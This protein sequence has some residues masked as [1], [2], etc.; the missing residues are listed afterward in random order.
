[1]TIGLCVIA[2]ASFSACEEAVIPVGDINTPMKLDTISFPIIKAISYQSPP[3]MGKTDYLYFGKKD[4]YEFKYS[5][6]KFDSSSMT[7][8]TPLSY[9]N[10]SLVVVDSLQLS[11]RFEK[12]SIESNPEFQLRY[13]PDGGDSVFSEL[14]SHYLNFDRAIASSII[15]TAQMVRNTEDTNSTKV[16]LNF[17]LD[18]S[19]INV[20]IDT[21]VLNFNRSF[22]V[23]LKNDE[24]ESFS[25]RSMDLGD[26]YGPQLTVFFRQLQSDT[27]SLDTVTRL[28]NA[29]SDL[30]V[31]VPPS[32]TYEDTT[33]LSVSMSKGLKSIVMVDMEGWTLPEKSV[34]SNAELFF[35][36]VEGDS[37]S[38]YS[39]VSHP[40]KNEGAYL[41]FSSFEEDPYEEDYN[42]YTST[43]IVN[44]ELR[45]NHRKAVTQ[46][47]LANFTNNGFKLQASFA[48]DPFATVFFYGLKDSELYPVMRIIYVSP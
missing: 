48:N 33:L 38:D 6:I 43:R 42:Y 12:D 26:G 21:T 31:I 14:N 46:I 15:S 44:D 30:S 13:F 23:E 37:I 3:Q 9:F 32:L 1:M 20:L 25:F 28:Y 4:G 2:S 29:V 24:T 7:A 16:Y 45:I 10:N 35:N 11:L 36:R 18:S 47:G 34:I 22:L 41:I 39:I 40:I 19:I 5:L 17:S 8:R 27:T